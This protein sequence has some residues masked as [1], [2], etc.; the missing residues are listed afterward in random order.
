[1]TKIN[2]TGNIED[3]KKQVEQS[4]ATFELLGNRSS[5]NFEQWF[6]KWEKGFPEAIEN[7]TLGNYPLTGENAWRKEA[8]RWPR[9]RQWSN[10]NGLL[11]GEYW[12]D[13]S[14]ETDS[15][16][17]TGTA[18]QLIEHIIQLEYI[19][20][21]EDQEQFIDGDTFSYSGIPLITL[22][23]RGIDKNSSGKNQV[24]EGRK[25]F[26][27]MGYTDNPSVATQEQNLELITQ[28]N[29]SQ[30]GNKISSIFD[31]DPPYIWSKG[32]KQVVY[33]DWM[34]GF[35][36]NVY[37]ST[38]NEGERLIAAI[39]SLRNLQINEAF[40]KYSEPKNPLQAYPPARD[41]EVLG[42]IWS[43]PERL[44]K[45]DVAF[46]YAKIY[47]PTIKQRKIIA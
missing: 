18:E 12:P 1:M 19:K 6:E 4:V 24:C 40:V 29:I 37:A 16:P 15:I 39:L 47:L 21:K 41:F 2:F 45:V 5:I 25:S 42:E 9:W 8:S 14:N 20:K 36:L 22:Y 13:R 10:E 44:P 38:H 7:R 46:R 23:F 27:F 17:L 34:R 26:R 28:G 43:K 30:I 31:T 11:S 32:K 3:I 35:N 33:H